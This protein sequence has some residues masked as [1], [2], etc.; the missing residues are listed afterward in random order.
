M[1]LTQGTNITTSHL[2][3][4]LIRACNASGSQEAIIEINVIDPAID[5]TAKQLVIKSATNSGFCYITGIRVGNFNLKKIPLNKTC[6]LT[7]TSTIKIHK[8]SQ[9]ELCLGPHKSTR[10]LNIIQYA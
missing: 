1:F 10:S 9:Y 3:T 4:N 7:V 6:T 2:V 8:G 5:P